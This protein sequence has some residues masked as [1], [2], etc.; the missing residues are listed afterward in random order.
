MIPGGHLTQ[1]LLTKVSSLFVTNEHSQIP[2]A[3]ASQSG[4]EED[5]MNGQHCSFFARYVQLK[6]PTSAQISRFTTTW[7]SPRVQYP[8]KIV[9]NSAQFE[10][11]SQQK[12]TWRP[13]RS[14]SG[15]A[16]KAIVMSQ[17]TTRGYYT[18]LFL[19]P[20]P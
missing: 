9:E 4:S 16:I 15:H 8:S 6:I 20:N 17:F 1:K 7:L 14:S 2:S 19:V 11:I 13:P 10:R 5:E 12:Q 3:R 18:K